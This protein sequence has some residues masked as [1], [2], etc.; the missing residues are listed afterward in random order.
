MLVSLGNLAWGHCMFNSFRKLAPRILSQFAAIALL[1]TGAPALAQ[2]APD[3]PDKPAPRYMVDNFGDAL[4]AA[5]GSSIRRLHPVALDLIKTFEGWI[6]NF[7][8][9][10]AG[11]CTIGYGHLIALRRCQTEDYALF[12]AP[13]DE[14]F[15]AKLLEDDTQGA[16]RDVQRLVTGTTL[17][18]EQFG[19]LTSFVFNV[20]SGNFASSTLLRRLNDTTLDE[21]TRLSLATREFPRWVRAGGQ[22]F[23]GLVARRACEQAL[24]SGSLML[25][26]SGEFDRRLCDTLGAIP[27]ATDLIDI[28]DGETQ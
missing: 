7:Y 9:D 2:E 22:V 5:P 14:P 27:D 18:D 20:G 16:R 25:S 6:P 17:T 1:C 26:S 8:N 24:F 28:E 13:M 10:P 21:A 19:A 15:G 4:G 12:D 23:S 3:I 11:Y